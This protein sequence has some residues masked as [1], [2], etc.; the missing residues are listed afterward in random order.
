M[1]D[2]GYYNIA[3]WEIPTLVTDDQ[4]SGEV[5]QVYVNW[6]ILCNA[7]K[8]CLKIFHVSEWLLYKIL[9]ERFDKV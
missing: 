9:M 7:F 5:G 2:G 3:K 6:C 1:N 4:W 8:W